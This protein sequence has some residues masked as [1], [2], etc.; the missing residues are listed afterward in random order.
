M[1]KI[2]I[3]LFPVITHKLLFTKL[4]LTKMKLLCF[5]NNDNFTTDEEYYIIVWFYI[6]LNNDFDIKVGLS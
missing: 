6:V 5:E 4:V 3:L 1:L 2:N